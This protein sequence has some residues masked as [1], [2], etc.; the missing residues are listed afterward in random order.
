MSAAALSNWLAATELSRTIQI[1][2]WII[3]TLQTIHILSIAVLFSSAVLVDLRL[4]RL[5]EQDLPVKDVTRRFLPVIWPVLLILLTSGTLLI[6]AEPKRSLLN[7]TFYLKMGLLIAAILLTAGIQWSLSA[8]PNFWDKT[9]SRLVAGRLAAALSIV[10]WAGVII[11]GRWI[12]Y[13][14]V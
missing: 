5:F 14:A 8:D 11:A 1:A 12:A 6:I 4:W 3:P 9:K 7:S 2:G 10:I 13:T